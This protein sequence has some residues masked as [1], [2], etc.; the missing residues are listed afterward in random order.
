MVEWSDGEGRVAG[1]NRE[2]DGAKIS[3]N[4]GKGLS[5]LRIIRDTLWPIPGHSLR[6]RYEA[7]EGLSPRC[8]DQG[9][10]RL[11]V[12]RQAQDVQRSPPAQLGRDMDSSYFSVG[13]GHLLALHSCVCDIGVK[14]WNSDFKKVSK[15]DFN[16]NYDL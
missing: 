6:A 9:A 14:I 3:D 8:G 4:G 7:M 11:P 1:Q 2:S 13:S 5:A 16:N 15:S 12:G 10:A